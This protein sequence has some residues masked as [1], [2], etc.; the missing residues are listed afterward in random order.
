[1]PCGCR[2][3]RFHPARCKSGARASRQTRTTS[4]PLP[5]LGKTGSQGR[6]YLT[7]IS[8]PGSCEFSNLVLLAQSRS[9]SCGHQRGGA[10]TDRRSDRTPPACSTTVD[11]PFTTCG[12]RTTGNRTSAAA[13]RSIAASRLSPTARDPSRRRRRR[14][15]SCSGWPSEEEGPLARAGKGHPA[16]RPSRRQ[17]RTAGRR[18][19]EGRSISHI[20]R[21][22]FGQPRPVGGTGSNVAVGVSAFA[23]HR[24]AESE[25]VWR[26]NPRPH[27]VRRRRKH[28]L[29]SLLRCAFGGPS[30]RYAHL[31][32]R[33]R[34]TRGDSRFQHDGLG[35]H[36]AQVIEPVVEFLK[37]LR[38]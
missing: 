12:G 7:L 31:V 29:V 36:G 37:L 4:P 27:L 38:I 10:L 21:A 3:S 34:H 5:H 13:P 2:A 11:P 18:S 33:P 15:Y 30:Y 22:P 1:M 28:L 24:A 6:Q 32:R 17:G 25:Q 23:G 14:S 9:R 19:L 26:F 8:C 20:A 16:A 35:E